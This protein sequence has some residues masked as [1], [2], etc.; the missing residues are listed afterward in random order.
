MNPGEEV[1]ICDLVARAFHEFIAP[2]YSAEGVQEFL[3][4]AHP[5]AL[6]KRAESGHF[7]LVAE[8]GHDLAGMIE[9]RAYNHIAML[10]VDR[11]FHRQGIAKELV[12]RALA[13]GQRSQPDLK[14]ITV[15]SS[16]YALPIYEKM[17]FRSTNTEQ[18]VHGIRFIPMTLGV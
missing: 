2:D 16:P 6:R 10:F 7:V 14:E 15:N 11:A 12:Q 17:G 4:Y 9:V 18:V 5:D 8:A 1:A 3:G 13:I